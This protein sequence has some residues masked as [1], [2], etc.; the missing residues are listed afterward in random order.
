MGVKF[1]ENN[2][3]FIRFPSFSGEVL[4]HR[5]DIVQTMLG[6][7]ITIAFD[8]NYMN[9]IFKLDDKHP[10][11]INIVSWVN[12][13]VLDIGNT[14][15]VSYM[16]CVDSIDGDFGESVMWDLLN[17]L[18]IRFIP[19][20]TWGGSRTDVQKPNIENLRELHPD[21]LESEECRKKELR[22]AEELINNPRFKGQIYDINECVSIAR[23]IIARIDS[24]CDIYRNKQHVTF[25]E[26]INKTI[27][28]AASDR[29]KSIRQRNTDDDMGA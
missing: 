1:Y 28:K 22:A 12:D 29:R 25:L 10:N 26:K 20:T 4:G 24:I 11:E 27:E 5:V 14:K 16:Y 15:K 13:L 21:F 2:E 6:Y 8:K 17:Q 18:L 9:R 23:R 19:G 3:T 7:N